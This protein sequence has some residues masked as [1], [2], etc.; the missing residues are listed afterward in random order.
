LFDPNHN[1]SPVNPVPPVALILAAPI[2]LIEL[3]LQ[4]AEAGLIGG[5]DAIGWR[6]KLVQEFAF[7]DTIW[8]AMLQT[9]HVQ[10]DWIWRFFTYPFISSNFGEAMVGSVIVLG[11]ATY[12]GKRF[13]P[14]KILLGFFGPTA[15]AAVA[16]GLAGDAPLPL[17]GPFPAAFGLL[18][19]YSFLLWAKERFAGGSGWGAFRLVGFLITLHVIRWLIFGHGKAV[20]AEFVALMTGLALSL[21]ITWTGRQLVKRAFNWIRRG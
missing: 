20:F 7:F 11:V 14:H 2:V 13:G 17:M 8:E 19:V 9:R 6:I 16:Y 5:P 10:P 21:Y 15:V 3:V 12:L 4:L 1:A 18:G